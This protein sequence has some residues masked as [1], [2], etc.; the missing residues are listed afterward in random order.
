M[1]TIQFSISNT[2]GKYFATTGGH[3]F[4]I[5]SETVYQGRHG[6]FNTKAADGPV[7]KPQDYQVQYPYWASFIYPTAMCESKGSFHC[8]N[9]YDRAA[10]TFSF[11]Q[12]AAHVPNGDFVHYLR[13]LLKLSTAKDYFPFL[14]LRE[15][16]IWYVNGNTQS[17]LETND[18]TAALMKYLNAD[19]Q[20]ID[21]QE[22]ITAARFVHW[23]QNSDAHR[24]LQVKLAIE[25]FKT[26]MRQHA[27]R[28]NLDGWPDYICLVICDIL[29]QGRAKYALIHNMLGS[30]ANKETVY[31]NLVNIGAS[32]YADRIKTL[33]LEIKKLRDSG[34][35][36]K[37]YNQA[38]GAFE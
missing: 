33:K 25:L 18:S 14:E 30:A 13:D 38:L 4:Y 37:K 12:F 27:T 36:G 21:H 22:Q 8:L 23:A 9:S 10:F 6:L 31:N 34:V 24:A 17:Q 26:N 20:S 5:A 3:T 15:N 32:Q 7:Y 19:S 2:L 29:H 28:F 1:P 16:R 35:F 11:M